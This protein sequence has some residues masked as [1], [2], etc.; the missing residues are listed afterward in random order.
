M[1][2]RFIILGLETSII[3]SESISSEKVHSLC[4]HPLAVKRSML[5]LEDRTLLVANIKIELGQMEKRKTRYTEDRR[6]L[7]PPN[8]VHRRKSFRVI[9]NDVANQCITD[10]PCRNAR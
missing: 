9:T 10:T 7:G 3:C 5:G 4:M 6:G 1:I 8:L 2:G